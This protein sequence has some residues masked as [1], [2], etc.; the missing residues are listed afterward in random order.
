M[1]ALTSLSPAAPPRPSP[2]PAT[3]RRRPHTPPSPRPRP[4]S[5][6]GRSLRAATPGADDYH[7]TIRSLNSRGRHVPRKSLGQVQLLAPEFTFF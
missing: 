4:S 5:C 6:R 2:S 7:A 3:P 1:V